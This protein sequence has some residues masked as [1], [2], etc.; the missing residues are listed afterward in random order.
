[1]YSR[2]ETQKCAALI[3]APRQK[4]TSMSIAAIL[5][6]KKNSSEKNTLKKYRKKLKKQTSV[7][8]SR[9]CQQSKWLTV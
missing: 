6:E 4:Q 7:C 3:V 5:N 1:M 2:V 9:R 8:N